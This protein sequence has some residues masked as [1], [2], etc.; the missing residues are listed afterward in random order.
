[1]TKNN[2]VEEQEILHQTD[3][4][5]VVVGKSLDFDG[6]TPGRLLYQVVNKN[7]QVVEREDFALAAAIMTAN[8]LDEQLVEVLGSTS[9][10]TIVAH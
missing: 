9:P 7:T 4:Y 2:T 6:P 1:M 3:T 5:R 8:M 10:L